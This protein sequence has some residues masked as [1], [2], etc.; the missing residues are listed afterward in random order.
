VPPLSH[1]EG[2]T[3]LFFSDTGGDAN[4]G[5]PAPRHDM[6]PLPHSTQYQQ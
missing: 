2:S 1:N 5:I 4:S 6:E 3:L